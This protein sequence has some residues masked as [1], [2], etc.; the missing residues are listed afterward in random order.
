MVQRQ[1]KS[2]I[3]AQARVA[4]VL[5]SLMPIVAFGM[6]HTCYTKK[7]KDSRVAIAFIYIKEKGNLYLKVTFLH[8]ERLQLYM[9]RHLQ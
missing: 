2:H 9:Y 4:G 1:R 5:E 3:T 7:Y 6:N 8:K